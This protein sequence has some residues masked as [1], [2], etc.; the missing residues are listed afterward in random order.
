MLFYFFE[1]LLFLRIEF[2]RASKRVALRAYEWHAQQS[3][4]GID[5]EVLMPR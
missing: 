1:F 2:D 5:G 4:L 3:L